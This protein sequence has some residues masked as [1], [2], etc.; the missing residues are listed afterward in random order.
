MARPTCPDTVV[1]VP[2]QHAPVARA[3]KDRVRA[4]RGMYRRLCIAVVALCILTPSAAAAKSHGHSPAWQRTLRIR[5]RRSVLLDPLED[6]TLFGMRPSDRWARRLHRDHRSAGLDHLHRRLD[7]SGCSAVGRSRDKHIGE[8]KLNGGP[9]TPTGLREAYDLPS[10]SAGLRTDRGHRR[11]LRRPRRGIGPRQISP[12]LWTVGVHERQRLLQ[13]GQ[14]NGGHHLS[15]TPPDHLGPEISLD[16]DMVSA[17]CPKCHILLVEATNAERYANLTA[18][19]NEAVALGATVVNDS[20]GWRGVLRR[21]RIGP[22][23]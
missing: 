7:G 23:L 5:T 10:E 3:P 15:R 13:E 14:P 9:Y 4:L 21:D 12:L 11:C 17:A 6:R 18:A 22:V 2:F 1:A 20:W 19:E 16:V 8:N